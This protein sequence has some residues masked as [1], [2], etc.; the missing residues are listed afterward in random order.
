LENSFTAS[1]SVASVNL[2]GP[3]DGDFTTVTT[4]TTVAETF[5]EYFIGTL[6]ADITMNLPACNATRDG[7]TWRF[8]KKG[9]DAFSF[10]LDPAGAETFFDGAA[11]KVFF[12]Q[13]NGTTCVCENGL[14]WIILRQ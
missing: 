5:Y 9:T 6:T 2:K 12:G 1:A 3:L 4:T 13:G 7:W 10:T 11:T 8:M 14:G